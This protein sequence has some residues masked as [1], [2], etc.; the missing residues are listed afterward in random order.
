MSFKIEYKTNKEQSD[1]KTMELKFNWFSPQWDD[2]QILMEIMEYVY[3]EIPLGVPDYELN[4]TLKEMNLYI[5]KV[6]SHFNKYKKIDK[7]H[8]LEFLNSAI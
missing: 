7:E 5:Q 3:I 1:F 8:E 2:E 6:K 4:C